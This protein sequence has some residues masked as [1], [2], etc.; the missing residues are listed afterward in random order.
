MLTSFSK[1]LTS[2]LNEVESLCRRLEKNMAE[3]ELVHYMLKE[4][5]PEIGYI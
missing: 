1:S 4:L 3:K 5:R 2:Y